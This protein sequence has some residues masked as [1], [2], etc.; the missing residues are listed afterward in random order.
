MKNN[1]IQAYM[2]LRSINGGV[3]IRPSVAKSIVTSANEAALED[4]L[5]KKEAF[6]TD[7]LSFLIG[8]YE[9]NTLETYCKM[10]DRANADAP[11]IQLF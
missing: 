2:H 10:Y 7:F 1:Q 3:A 8:S 5:S 6:N 9:P 11:F 4:I